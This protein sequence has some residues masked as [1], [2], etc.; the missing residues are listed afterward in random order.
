MGEE[1]QM[2]GNAG[3]NSLLAKKFGIDAK[4]NREVRIYML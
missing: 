2:K 1:F 3:D 4:G